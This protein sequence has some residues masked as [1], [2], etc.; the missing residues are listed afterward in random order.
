MTSPTPQPPA[1]AQSWI[2]M[3]APAR[4]RD[5]VLGDLL[6]EYHETQVPAVGGAA[7]DRWFKRQAHGFLWSASVLPGGVM[8]ALISM[9]VLR[10]PAGLPLHAFAAW[11]AP[12]AAAH[13][14]V[15]ALFVLAGL[16][17]GLSTRRVDG[18]F[19]VAPT[20]TLMASVMGFAAAFG[21]FGIPALVDHS[22]AAAAALYDATDIPVQIMLPVGIVLTLM[23]AAIG[24]PMPI[25][26]L[27][28]RAS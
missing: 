28:G 25:S 17:L 24:A 2:E 11:T 3:L 10:D 9:G 8:G 6:E 20:V 21:A 16:R 7:A 5:A 4:R 26:R 14:A 13:Y 27:K 1:W 23:G 15:P 18:A 12:A 22:A 19:L